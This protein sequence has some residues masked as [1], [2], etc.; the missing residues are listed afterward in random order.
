VAFRACKT[1]Y[2]PF[3]GSGAMRA[4]ARWN[5]AGR[6]VVYASDSFA[7]AILDLLAHALRPRTL[8][9]PHHAV[10]I[11]VPQGLVEEAPI[12]VLPGW[13]EPESAVAREFGDQWLRQRRSAALLVP[14]LPCRPLG[15]NLLLNPEHPA[16]RRIRVSAPF[17]V[18]WDERLF[19]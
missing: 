7:G 4:G 12:E 5:S 13:E 15:R 6:P 17:A 10:R 1:R 8:P 18:P 16:T 3:D 19:R 14:A 9:G 11:E 2:D